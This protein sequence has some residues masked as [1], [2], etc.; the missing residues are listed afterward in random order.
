M[1]THTQIPDGTPHLAF[2]DPASYLSFVWTGN[3][4]DDIL[5]QRGGYG[6]PVIATVH[7]LTPPWELNATDTIAAFKIICA[8]WVETW[9][10]H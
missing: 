8:R 7:P 2:Y 10:G 1:T 5:V 3:P 4:D 9:E 6:E